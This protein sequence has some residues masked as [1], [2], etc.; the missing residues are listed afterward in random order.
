MEPR[1]AYGGLAVYALAVVYLT[2]IVE[3]TL[4]G[5]LVGGVACVIHAVLHD[6]PESFLGGLTP[7]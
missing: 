5:V 3:L 4:I 6:A 1:F 7:P 2:N